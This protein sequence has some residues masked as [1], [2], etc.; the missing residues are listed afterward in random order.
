[1][2]KLMLVIALCAPFVSVAVGHSNV[3]NP[4]I[5]YI[6]TGPQSKVYHSSSRCK[7]LSKCSKEIKKVTLE[8]AKSMNRRACKMCY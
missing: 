7:G 5:V 1:M 8:K 2:K 4:Q 6:C 3:S